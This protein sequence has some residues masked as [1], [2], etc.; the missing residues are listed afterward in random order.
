M[1]IVRIV[2]FTH[3]KA[4]FAILA[5][6]HKFFVLLF[7][8]SLISTLLP[9]ETYA[10]FLVT[11]DYQPILVF[12]NSDD[13]QDYLIRIS[14]DATDKYYLE[15]MRLQTLKQQE[16]TQKVYD[17]LIKQRSPLADYAATLVTLRNW[18]Q[19]VALANA[20]STLCRSYPT[21]KANCWGVGGSDLWDMG[22][23]LGEGCVTMNHFLNYYPKRSQVKYSDMS[24]ERM[25]GLYKQPA[26]E[27]WQYN[28]QTV[29]DDL[30]AIE[31]SL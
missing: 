6:K 18:K 1:D 15:Q 23:N 3:V 31:K 9:H 29:Y 17:Y 4:S 21:T 7:L 13:Y 30:V 10:A 27:H 22:D 8:L 16:L 24:F 28:A 11:S 2:K 26:A 14:Q 19:I 20:E 12:D 25:N 5:F